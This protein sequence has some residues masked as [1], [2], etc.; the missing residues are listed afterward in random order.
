MIQLYILLGMIICYILFVIYCKVCYRFWSVQPVFHL[1]NLYYWLFPP[2]IIQHKLPPFT[3]FYDPKVE[4][5]FWTALGDKKKEQFYRLNEQ[6]YLQDK[7]ISYKP[8]RESI[9]SYFEAH[10]DPCFISLL[11]NDDPLFHHSK[12][13]IIPRQTCIA[14]L[15][16]RPLSVFLHGTPL[17]VNYVDYLCVHKKHR[18]KGVAPKMI[19]S[20]YYSSRRQHNTLAYLFKR[21]GVAT[22]ITPMTVYLTYGFNIKT[23]PLDPKIRKPLLV[24]PSTFQSFYHYLQTIKK[25]FPCFVRPAFSHL[26]YLIEKKLL[27]VFLL[28]EQ[29]TPIGC[30]V[31][32][33]PFT[34]Y[35][36]GARSL[37]CIASYCG[38]KDRRDHFIQAF[39]NCLSQIDYAY[40][41]LIIENISHNNHIIKNIRRFH[42]PDF[43]SNTSYYLYNFGY[44]PF[45]SK[46]VF[47]LS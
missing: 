10:N 9:F 34:H 46:E 3:K 12:N 23:P 18:K 20:Y 21:E 36:G 8:T 45:P 16:S 19:Y 4:F 31:F 17:K 7:T 29:K 5:H 26:K 14:S 6:F 25:E 41:H 33:N 35:E 24:T 11:F 15:T 2:G 30:Y 47:F 37:D 44:R 28:L 40:Q 39:Y 22:F 38:R 27:Y 32:R 43:K 13:T 42:K 1:H